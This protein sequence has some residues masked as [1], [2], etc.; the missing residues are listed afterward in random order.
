LVLAAVI[1]AVIALSLSFLLNRR[2]TFPG[3]DDR[4][5]GRALRFVTVWL[6]FVVIALP[7]LVLLVEVAHLPRVLSQAIIISV[8]APVS[9]LVQ[10]N[11][12]FRQDARSPAGVV[13]SVVT[14]PTPDRVS[15]GNA[16]R[17]DRQPG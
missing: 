1:A 3:T 7:T 8:G 17:D 14:G 10:R 12:T 2:W 13:E 9:Y 5:S 6:G 4:T 15:V 16:A 11:W